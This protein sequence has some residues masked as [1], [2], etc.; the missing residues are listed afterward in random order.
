MFRSQNAL[1]EPPNVQPH[2]IS[3]GQP[4]GGGFGPQDLRQRIV[5]VR[6][7]EFYGGHKGILLPLHYLD[8]R[9]PR[10]KKPDPERLTL[11]RVSQYQFG[12]FV[13]RPKG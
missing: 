6:R 1:D 10:I 8:E 12:L 11:D 2:A 9:F 4:L 7:M 5:G 3:H 13:L